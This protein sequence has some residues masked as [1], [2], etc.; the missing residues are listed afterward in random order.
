MAAVSVRTWE[1]KD[2]EN[3]RAVL[4]EAAYSHVWP[5]FMLT[6]NRQWFKMLTMAV[7]VVVVSYTKSAGVYF[8][9]VLTIVAMA[10]LAH[11]VTAIFYI[12]GPP[13]KEMLKVTDV[14]INNEDCNFWVAEDSNNHQIVGTIAIVKKECPGDSKVAWLRRMAVLKSH[15]GSGIGKQ[16]VKTAVEFCRNR[17]YEK[18]ELITTEVHESARNLYLKE[19]FVCKGFKPYL[20][21]NGW[22]KIWTYEFE[23]EIK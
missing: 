18:V 16:L 22:V 17:G 20:Y 9:T 14:Y 8:G 4:K 15:R 3:V 19:G 7:T 6:L 13:L 23:Y 1:E 10:H 21:L 11:L 12:Y 2:G 5:G